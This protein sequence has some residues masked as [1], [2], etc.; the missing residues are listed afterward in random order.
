MK[1]I[2][3]N[4]NMPYFKANLHC[5]TVISDGTKTPE[6][7]KEMY[8]EHGYSIVAYTDHNVLLDH[9]DLNDGD[10]LALNA[11]EM[12]INQRG[13]NPCS[14]KTC[15]LCF[16]ALKP[17]N[18]TQFCYHRSAYLSGNAPKY[19]DLIRFDETK[20]DFVR[21]YTPDCINEMIAEGRKNSFFV[22]YNHPTWSQEN[23][24]DYTAYHGMNAME[25]C[26]YGC[27]ESGYPD[28]NEKEYD[29][30]LKNGERIFCTATDDNHNGRNDSFGGFTMINAENLEYTTITDALEKGNFYASEAPLISEVWYCDGKIGINCSPAREIRLNT[31]I[32]RSQI[33][34]TVGDERVTSAVFDVKDSDGYVRIT[35]TDAEGKHANTNAYFVD[36]LMKD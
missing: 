32:R 33:K 35:V 11:F 15:H 10:F 14:A 16:I 8:K 24:K 36:E 7:I 5:H 26:N 28:Y 1:K 23:Y 9:S 17:D 19:R 30:I 18:L 12:D 25:I 3:L 20:P 4:G 29:D 13:E 6:E 22:T 21:E 31:A 27:V 34:Y 2:L